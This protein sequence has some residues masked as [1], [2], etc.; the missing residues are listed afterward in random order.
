MKENVVTSKDFNKYEEVRKSG[1]FNMLSEEAREAT[2]LSKRK[3]SA[4]I[5]Q[6]TYCLKR[7]EKYPDTHILLWSC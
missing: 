1:R 6:Y 7:L 3:Y 2:G 5:R 4:I